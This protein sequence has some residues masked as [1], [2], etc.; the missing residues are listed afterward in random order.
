MLEVE[1]KYRTSDWDPLVRTITEWG[2]IAG[3]PRVEE[4]RYFN[5]PDRDFK[6]TDEAVRLRRIGAANRL[7]YKGPK[8]DTAT[9][10]RP[11]VEVPL[12]DGPAAAESA[13]RFLTG[14]GFR[15]V[16]TVRKTRQL[17]RFDRHGFAFEACLDD[18]GDIGR[19]V[20]LEIRADE[21]QYD[22]AKAALL[23]TADELG[24]A[25]QER[26]SYLEMNMTFR[27]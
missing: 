19:F 10:T 14:L 12:A 18:A 8:L 20:E 5:A 11:E 3:E 27:G 9:K 23:R 4:D 24:L 22:D 26:R 6:R 25:E 7:T 21:I 1:V 16:A 13:V 17:Y 2:A 15:P